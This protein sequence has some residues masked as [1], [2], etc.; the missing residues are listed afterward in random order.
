MSAIQGFLM[1]ESLWRNGQ[2]FQN[3]PL[4]HGCPGFHCIDPLQWVWLLHNKFVS[5]MLEDKQCTCTVLSAEL[6]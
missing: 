2:D 5:A 1:Y 6:V 4:Y 3:C